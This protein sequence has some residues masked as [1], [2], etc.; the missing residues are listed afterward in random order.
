MG[1][2]L[3]QFKK[4]LRWTRHAWFDSYIFVHINKTAGSSIEKALN[5]P[6]EH[7]TAQ[8]KIREIGR[9]RWDKKWTFTFVRN[10]W[11]RVVSHYHHRVKTNQTGLGD[12]HIDFIEWVKRAYGSRDVTYYDKPKMFMP[13]TNWIT[14]KEGKVVVDDIM[15]FENLENDFHKMLK[16]LGKSGTLPHVRKSDRGNFRQYY[17]PETIE[18]VRNWFERDIEMFG[19]QFEE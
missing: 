8:E 10:P 15:R 19:Y 3:N 13:Q 9:E 11:D 18:I 5:I 16:K 12:K 2:K 6:L 17:D 1:R 7:K 14:D 4:R